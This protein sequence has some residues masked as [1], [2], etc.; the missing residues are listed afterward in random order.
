MTTIDQ[1]TNSEGA[2]NEIHK[3]EQDLKHTLKKNLTTQDL[4]RFVQDS[5]SKVYN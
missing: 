4:S 1:Y 5:V 2:L 3:F